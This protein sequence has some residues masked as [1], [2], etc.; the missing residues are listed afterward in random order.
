L[1]RSRKAR[2]MNGMSLMS[3]SRCSILLLC[4]GLS[5]LTHAR[6][7]AESGAGYAIPAISAQALSTQTQITMPGALPSARA[8]SDPNDVARELAQL[9]DR[10]RRNDRASDRN[11]DRHVLGS[12]ADAAWLLG[13]IHVHGA[14]TVQDRAQAQLWFERAAQRGHPLAT[15][16]VSWCILEGCQSNAN[17]TLA[18]TRLAQLRVT[19]ARVMEWQAQYQRVQMARQIPSPGSPSAQDSARLPERQILLQAARAGDL[20][21]ALELGLES[22]A[23]GDLPQARNWL[24]MASG[25]GSAAAAHNLRLLDQQEQQAQLRG[26]ESQQDAITLLRQAQRL[27]RGEGQPVNYTEA[28]RL[29]REAAAKGNTTARDML[30]LIFSRPAPP[31][32]SINIAWMQ[33]IA[34]LTLTDTPTAATGVAPVANLSSQI[35]PM[36]RREPTLLFDYLPARWQARVTPVL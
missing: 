17:P 18:L 1:I 10:A 12:P 11:Q 22:I 7:R 27:H 36:F 16:G 28:I 23:L 31:G 8:A 5:L 6:T 30:A 13:L 4:L 32:Q 19:R 20:H 21:A 29:Y 9:S 15:L 35:R 14:G 34:S 25:A 33:Q 3:M 2:I 26:N 24:R